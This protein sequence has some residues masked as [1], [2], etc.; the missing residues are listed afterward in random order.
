[1]PITKAVTRTSVLVELSFDMASG[2]ATAVIKHTLD[3]QEPSVV[4]YTVDG[5][6]FAQM[7]ATPGVAGQS[8]ADQVT[9]AVYQYLIGAGLVTGDIS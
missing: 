5:A 8:L 9:N 7:L 2:I 6:K 3:G 1:M 4:R